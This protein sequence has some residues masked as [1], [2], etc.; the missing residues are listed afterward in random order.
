MAITAVTA[1]LFFSLV[2]AGILEK[3]PTLLGSAL[4]STGNY[5]CLPMLNP[6]WLFRD[7]RPGQL[8]WQWQLG[9]G[10]LAMPLM[11]VNL[12]QVALRDWDE[13]VVALIA[14]EMARSPIGSMTW[15]YPTTADGTPYF[16]KPPL[17]HWLVALCFQLGGSNEWMARLPGATLTILSVPLLYMIGRELFNQRLPA[18]FAA[19]T[20]LTLLPIVRHG[21]MAM[22]DGA[23]VC[24][25][26]LFVLCILRSRR[27]LRW[28]L[29][30]G[31]A[32][33]LIAM[34]KG[35]AALLLGAIAVV[36]LAWDTPRLLTSSYAWLGVGLGCL[37]A[38]AWYLAQWHHY[39]QTFFAENFVNQ[40]LSR[41]WR[42]VEQNQG[43]LWYYLLEILKYA[44]PW[45]IFL[46]QAVSLAWENRNLSWARLLLI[47]AGG[48]L[49]VVSLMQTKLPWYILP[50]Y[51]ALALMV[52]RQLAEGWRSEVWLGGGKHSNH[53]PYPLIWAI[54][55]GIAA[56]ASIAYGI[57]L[58][59]TSSDP[60]TDLLVILLAVGITLISAAILIGRQNSEFVLILFWGCYVAL[61]LLMRSPHWL[62]EVNESYPVKP[63]A[64]IIA[65]HVPAQQVVWTSHR[66][67]RPSLNFYSDRRV[68]PANIEALKTIWQQD[69][70]S[71]LLVDPATLR[72][73]NLEQTRQL[74]EAE[75][76]LLVSHTPTHQPDIREY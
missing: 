55:L 44:A 31:V 47:W 25:F 1:P 14:R 30:V 28:S 33:A 8:D 17:I 73:L 5:I 12:G 7:R 57:Y 22:L 58:S 56:I 15:L 49:A 61:F 69:P 48:Y 37:P 27:N 67:H 53:T 38:I 51:P 70:S 68:L 72:L 4:R 39:G 71:Y 45:L 36:F 54:L 63:V 43:P 10:L 62:W 35:A 65:Q 50:I 23:L 42:T 59:L 46:P 41:A 52:G 75:G 9:L 16:N 40:S 32:L 34:T 24:F 6:I 66:F 18:I 64:Q 3:I 60:A 11:W 21:R 29:G 2:V 13:G 74:A 76:W 19:L 26:L 20:Y